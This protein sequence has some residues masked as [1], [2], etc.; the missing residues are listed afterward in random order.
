[1]IYYNTSVCEQI[2]PPEKKTGGNI[3]FENTKSEAGAVS[4]AALQGKGS[5][6]RS[7]F[8]DTNDILPVYGFDSINILFVRA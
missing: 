7:V 4:A 6:E 2:V 1:M 3:S 5:Q 8:S